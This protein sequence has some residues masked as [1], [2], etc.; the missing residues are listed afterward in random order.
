MLNHIEKDNLFLDKTVFSDEATFQLPRKIH[1]Y[2]LIIRGSQNPHQVIEH[3][4]DSP[5][6]NVLCAVRKTQ[7]YGSFFFTETTLPV[8]C[9]SIIILEHFLVSHLDVKKAICNKTGPCPL[10]ERYDAVV[11]QTLPGKRIGR[12]GYIPWPPR[13]PDLTPMDFHFGDS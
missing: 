2:N 10:S 5:K 13:S 3:V 12:D 9:I 1:R 7:V 6:V 8:T 4:R 11:N